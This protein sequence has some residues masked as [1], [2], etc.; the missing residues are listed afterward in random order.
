MADFSGARL[1]QEGTQA[2]EL[3]GR[4]VYCILPDIG[5][6]EWGAI[7]LDGARVYTIGYRDICALVHDCPVEP[8][9]GDDETVKTW[10][11]THSEVIDAA[12]AETD[13]VLPMTFDCIIRPSDGHS[14]EETVAA[15]LRAEYDRFRAQLGEFKGKVELGV[16]I[17]WRVDEV[18]R[19]LAV[20][21][22]EID[23]LQAEM[24]GKPKGMA[25]FYQQKIEKALKA[26][27]EAKAD[28]DYRRYFQAIAAE[29][30]DLRVSKVKRP[31]DVA[32]VAQYLGVGRAVGNGRCRQIQHVAAQLL[33][34]PASKRAAVQF[35]H[36]KG[37]RTHGRSDLD[38]RTK[39]G[40][41][42]SNCFVG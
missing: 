14:V 30:E 10:V 34:Q 26:A 20:E 13:S 40:T 25:Y 5:R 24:G 1:D 32:L 15:W 29:A 22:G 11:W 8:Y 16:Q 2:E 36:G 42:S 7:G 21:N 6:D 37:H 18:S 35:A 23:R 28:G 31:A 17:F 39:T 33:C 9:Q 41:N 12:W 38:T 4:Y 3:G 27:L 19:A